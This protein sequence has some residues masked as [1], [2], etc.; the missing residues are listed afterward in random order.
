VISP[1]TILANDIA[2]V[3]GSKH[4]GAVHSEQFPHRE[5]PDES[6]LLKMPAPPESGSALTTIER[7]PFVSVQVNVD[8]FG[9]DIPFDAANEPS[10]AVDPT[11]PDVV[12]IGWRQF[13]TISSSFRQAGVAFSHDGGETWNALP[14]LE[15]GLFRSDPVLA[16]GPDGT[17]YYYSLRSGFDCDL[18]R[19]FDGGATWDGPI[20]AFGGD[21]AWMTV[22]LTEGAGRGNIYAA[23]SFS[24]SCCGVNMFTRSTDGGETFV[25]PIEVPLTPVF[26]TMSVGPDGELYIAGVD[27][28]SFSNPD[29][30]ITRSC[31]IGTPGAVP[32]FELMAEPFMGGSLSGS[33]GPNP[34]GLLGQ[35]NVATDHSDGPTRSAERF[36]RAC[37]SRFR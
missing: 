18:F 15:A 23:W 32:T 22:D 37:R 35:V 8:I 3:S 21:K 13:D 5:A 33:A 1:L 34:V 6:S 24:F 27:L 28:P 36:V 4:D 29:F 12:V 25:F 20:P 16:A 31:D 9:L 30:V 7:G 10:I 26:G 2:Q 19:S 17:I 11:N 14:P